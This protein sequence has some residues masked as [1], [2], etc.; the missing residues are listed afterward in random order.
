MIPYMD[1]MGGI[2][3]SCSFQGFKGVICF[4]FFGFMIVA[5]ASANP[6]LDPI[7]IY[8]QPPPQCSLPKNH[9]LN[10]AIT[11]LLRDNSGDIS[12]SSKK[13]SRVIFL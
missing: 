6:A 13:H 5:P 11:G 10:E 3:M 4:L 8:A 9:D 7:G 12:N 1:P 2:V